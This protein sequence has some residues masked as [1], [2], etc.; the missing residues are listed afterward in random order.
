MDT[1]PGSP[2]AKPTLARAIRLD[3]V[4]DQANEGTKILTG[5][6]NLLSEWSQQEDKRGRW[7]RRRVHGEAG[8]QS[9]TGQGADGKER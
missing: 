2:P 9:E 8:Q 5:T 4:A 6:R 1:T 7:R 3:K